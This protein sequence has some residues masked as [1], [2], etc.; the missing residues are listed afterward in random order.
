MGDYALDCG[1]S[2]DSLLI[3][4]SGTYIATFMFPWLSHMVRCGYL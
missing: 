1:K 2:E 3:N 4:D